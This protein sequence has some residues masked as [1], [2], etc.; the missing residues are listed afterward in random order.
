M[1]WPGS[2]AMPDPAKPV[3]TICARQKGA[4]SRLSGA[5]PTIFAD[6][7]I[8]APGKL[9]QLPIDLQRVNPND[10]LSDWI[11]PDCYVPGRADCQ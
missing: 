9:P 4:L 11:I 10:P 6:A 8:L 7:R 1:I 2:Q 3:G 5:M